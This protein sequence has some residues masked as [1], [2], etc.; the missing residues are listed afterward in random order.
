MKNVWVAGFLSLLMPGIGHLYLGKVLK[1][2]VLIILNIVFITTMSTLVGLLFFL[3][4]W[5]YAIINSVRMVR[6]INNKS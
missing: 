6:F 5:I 2:V 4:N 1:G 3:A